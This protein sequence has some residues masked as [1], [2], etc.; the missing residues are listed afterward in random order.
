MTIHICT[1]KTQANI[2]SDALKS[3]LG[4]PNA[5]RSKVLDVVAQLNGMHTWRH[6][7]ALGKADAEQVPSQFYL[8]LPEWVF[9]LAKI[10]CGWFDEL[11]PQR[12]IEIYSAVANAGF[13]PS[14]RGEKL[15]EFRRR[16]G[17]NAIQA[18]IPEQYDEY[19]EAPYA[20]CSTTF[21]VV[22]ENNWDV[23][24][25]FGASWKEAM[26]KGLAEAE[27]QRVSCLDF[28]DTWEHDLSWRLREKGIDWEAQ[29]WRAALETL[30]K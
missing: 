23:S 1:L 20:F 22:D 14:Q 4:A 21:G 8:P 5:Q 10:Q 11:S 26:A 17:P 16:I 15:T 13:S 2:L 25:D 29:D 3:E 6:A 18:F 27:K 24:V 30:D 9:E 12:R 28:P 7:I 19:P